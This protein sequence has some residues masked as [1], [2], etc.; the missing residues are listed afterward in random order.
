MAIQDTLL[1]QIFHNALK[2]AKNQLINWCLEVVYLQIC[3]NSGY[4]PNIW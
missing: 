3:Q 4:H 1:P 2:F